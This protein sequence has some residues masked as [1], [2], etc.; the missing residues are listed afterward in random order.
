M[1][2]YVLSERLK[3][4]FNGRKVTAAVFHTFNFDSEF[5]ENYLLPLFLPDIPFGDNKIQ[6]T[7]LWKKFQHDLPPITVYCDFHAKAERGIHLKYLVRPIDIPRKNGVK[8][9]YHP[10]HSY[11]LL[12]D[13]E[14]LII[15]GS[16]N[17]TEAG[18]CSNLEGINLFKLK[19]NINFPREFKDQFKQFNRNIRE[20]FFDENFQNENSHSIADNLLDRFF[21]SQGYTSE[22]IDFYFDTLSRPDSYLQ[23]VESLIEYIRIE[24]NEEQ[25]FEQVEVISPYFPK[26]IQLFNKL[27]ELTDCDDI[28]I[29]IPQE[30]TNVVSL[31]KKLFEDVASIGIKWKV[32]KELKN[33]KGFRFNHSKIY[34]FV[35]VNQVFQ[36]VGSINFTN[37]AWKGVKQGGNYES[38]VIYCLPKE[39][40]V[41]LL[42]P[43][44]YDQ[45]TFTG[46]H[47]EE[48]ISDNREDVFKL[49]FTIDWNACVLKIQNLDEA[50]QHGKIEFDNLPALSINKTRDVKLNEEYIISLTNTPIIKVRPSNTSIYFYYYP[51]HENIESKPLPQ[52]LNLSDVELL[53]LWQ[54]L[55]DLGDI[56]GVLRIIDGFI[57]RITDESGDVN[58]EAL[59]ETQ[60]T[61]NLMAT[62]LSG[63]LKLEKRVFAK[64]HT[65]KEREAIVRMR[66]YYLLANNVDTLIGYRN[67][68]VKMSKEEKLN[69]GFYW[70]LLN[71]LDL[72]FYKDLKE[73]DFENSQ[74]FSKV[75]TIQKDLKKDING[76]KKLI[77]SD[78]LT[79]KHL[80]WTLKMLRDDI[81]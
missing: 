53:E 73:S 64:G 65:I 24:L 25:R 13:N 2:K 49:N 59:K 80:K 34:Q 45:L 22:N 11:I 63:L 37:M 33:T 75:E 36:I 16:N 35:G 7:I 14:L 70:L 39:K 21:R 15:T 69:N 8:P 60:S 44:D 38:A 50:N 77:V 23:D 27:K 62:H 5:F 3:E 32:I 20:T 17:L 43:C 58:N 12:E 42:E 41:S 76:L 52:Y 1:I 72:L 66:D 4:E 48:G 29:S 18:W 81:K 28:N 47:A 30:N 19:P 78:R 10:K 46:Q 54:E 68:L 74:D 9:C 40:Y 31:E 61:L 55:D 57:E 79:E 71:C 67:L 51:I 26:G 56:T 6:N